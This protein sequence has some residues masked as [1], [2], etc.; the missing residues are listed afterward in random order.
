MVDVSSKAKD[1]QLTD[2]FD[3]VAVINEDITPDKIQSA[4]RSS[5]PSPDKPLPAAQ[6][7]CRKYDNNSMGMGKINEKLSQRYRGMHRVS[8]SGSDSSYENCSGQ[9]ARNFTKQFSV[10]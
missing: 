1:N 10:T 3:Q 2:S 9:V 8:L 7:Q 5:I 6:L 4:F